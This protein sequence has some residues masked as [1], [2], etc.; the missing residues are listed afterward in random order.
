MN[1]A[2]PVWTESAPAKVTVFYTDLA[3]E[4]KE[5][6]PILIKRLNK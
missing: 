3:E 1:G 6:P 2:A 4:E 5:L